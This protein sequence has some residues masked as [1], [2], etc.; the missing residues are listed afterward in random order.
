[1]KSATTLTL[2]PRT[3]RP[4]FILKPMRVEHDEARALLLHPLEEGAARTAKR[5]PFAHL[6]RVVMDARCE[7]S[8]ATVVELIKRGIPVQFIDGQGRSVG[9]LLGSRRRETTLG[10][11]LADAL[12]DPAWESLYNP[13]REN[14]ARAINASALI[15]HGLRATVTALVDPPAAWANHLRNRWGVAPALTLRHAQA[16]WLG[17]VSAALAQA[18]DDPAL[19]QGYRAG[20]DLTADF[21]CALHGPLCADLLRCVR[22]PMHGEADKATLV[23]CLQDGASRRH[24]ALGEM[25][26]WFERFL[27]EHW[28]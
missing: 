25:I 17:E 18:V 22:V 1:M 6:S 14:A 9:H 12:V 10:R 8:L 2:G 4:L 23:G 16:L 21:A 19:L 7:C 3:A 15:S 27:R 26:G 11:L 13:W 28:A 20:V 5:V 24:E